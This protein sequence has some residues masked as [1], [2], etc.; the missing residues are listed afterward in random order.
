[1]SFLR[2]G[3][4]RR[5]KASRALVTVFALA[6]FQALAIVGAGSALAVTGC[7]FNPSNGAIQC[8]IDGGTT[9]DVAVE[10]AGD[11][12]PLAPSGAILQSVDGGTTWTA[13]GSASN[14]NTTSITVLGSPGTDETF[15][16]D[17]NVTVG[18]AP[19][20]G[21]FNT[22]ITWAIDLGTNTVAGDTLV[23]NAGEG[24]DTVVLTNG[25]FTLNG[26][27]GPMLGVELVSVA[28][29]GGADVL[30][31]SA[32]TSVV[33]T[34]TGGAGD[35]VLSPGVT[36][37]GDSVTGG[38]GI[39]TI[40]YSTATATQCIVINNPVVLGSGLDANCDGDVADVGDAADSLP[41]A[42]E[43]LQS[44]A[45]N[46]TLIGIAAFAET[47]IPGD[48][49]D[50]VT[51]QVE[52]TLDWSSSS[53]AMTIDSVLGSATG[54]GTD[55]WTGVTMFI[56][57]DF[58]DILIVGA[59][60]TPGGGATAFS[61]G[62]G[63]DTVDASAAA[64]GAGINLETLDD[65]I[66]GA[67]LADDLE[68][69]IG[70]AFNDSLTG[71]DLRNVL[72]AGDG[73]DTLFGAAGNDTLFGGLGND[74]F[75]GGTGADRVSF[76]N[77]PNGVNVDLSLGFATGEGDDSFAP[78]DVEIIVGSPFRDTITGGPFAGGGTVNFLFVGKGGNDV[79]TGF[80]GNDTLRAG[81][82]NDILRGVGGDDT[83]R[84]AK[85]NDRLFGGSGV[86]VGRGGPGKDVCRGVEIKSSCGTPGDPRAPQVARLV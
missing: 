11:L 49:N 71:N 2:R 73:D 47:F 44:G 32:L 15:T 68:N 45:G 8:T 35:D 60:A 33:V 58:D 84:G 83:L 66:L 80:N 61:G 3:K 64:A 21:Q 50:A 48:G 27:G 22:A 12:D 74:T 82:G 85:G 23:I 28:G 52:D 56:G 14:T 41:D 30:D 34:L 86:D 9:L 76:V 55:T 42:L 5:A 78:L 13:I 18:V 46:D 79:L 31:G 6:G 19:L 59:G 63:V 26:G 38:A 25:T 40:S 37:A 72:N 43:I 10:G 4:S 1:M 62:A 77:S 70:S 39:D 54:Q 67:T 7:T 17:N 75:S 81:P 29:N 16:I 57:S 24:A 51:G 20:S 36:T 69:A 65:P 53:A